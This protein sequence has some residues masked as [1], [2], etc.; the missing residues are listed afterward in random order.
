MFATNITVI[1]YTTFILN[2]LEEKQT[3]TQPLCS[4]QCLKNA[5]IN[6]RYTNPPFFKWLLPNMPGHLFCTQGNGSL[7]SPVSMCNNNCL[8]SQSCKHDKVY[9][10][11]ADISS[12]LYVKSNTFKKKKKVKKKNL[13]HF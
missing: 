10:N 12:L 4:S 3:Q 2:G 5:N 11:S 1:D 13:Q 6:M 9:R 7:Y 8:N